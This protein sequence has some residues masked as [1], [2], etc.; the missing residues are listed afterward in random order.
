M[1]RQTTCTLNSTVQDLNYKKNKCQ[2]NFAKKLYHH[3]T[4]IGMH[5]LSLWLNQNSKKNSKN[6]QILLKVAFLNILD[7][8]GKLSNE[9]LKTIYKSMKLLF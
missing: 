1:P 5:S 4:E 9:D 2:V 8:D 7:I 3:L 6:N